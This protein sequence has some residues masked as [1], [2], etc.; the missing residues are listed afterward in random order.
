[1]SS[2]SFLLKHSHFLAIAMMRDGLEF[3]EAC[4]LLGLPDKPMDQAGL[5]ERI[6]AEVMF[7][8]CEKLNEFY[9]DKLKCFRVGFTIQPTNYSLWAQLVSQ[10]STLREAW[11]SY[12][13]NF[14][15]L[16]NFGKPEVFETANEYILKS[17]IDEADLKGAEMLLELRIAAVA[18]FN[19]ILSSD[20]FPD[21]IKEVH[22]QHGPSAHL[23]LYEQI[24]GCK[25]VFNSDFTGLVLDR[26]YVDREILS[27]DPDLR[28]IVLDKIQRM[29]RDN[30]RVSVSQS[31]TELVTRAF[32]RAIKQ[33]EVADSLDMSVSSLK[34]RLAM[35]GVTYQEVLD[36][37][38]NLAAKSLL[39]ETNKSMQ[40]I[41]EELGFASLSSFSQTFRRLNDQSP[42]HFRKVGNA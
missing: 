28:R 12:I 29:N 8:A 13:D 20:M 4:R 26:K 10:H 33:V 31:V 24:A 3:S 6:S 34:R 39:T 27:P 21:L 5:S 32:P 22:F 14:N 1:M 19:Y 2:Y 41:A 35:E 15:R 38:R 23:N 36:R 17:C 42:S 18:K 7:R 40:M 25:V 30:D 37:A 9:G 11:Q 16:G